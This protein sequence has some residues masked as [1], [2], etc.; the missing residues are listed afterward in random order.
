MTIW[1]QRADAMSELRSVKPNKSRKQAS[2]RQAWFTALLIAV[3]STTAVATVWH[4]GHE[5]GQGC[6]VCKLRHQPLADLTDRAEPLILEVSEPLRESVT[7][8]VPIATRSPAPARAPP[9][10]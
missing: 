1:T 4:S 2:L 8:W 9:P 6:V 5:P 3:I 7:A 10:S